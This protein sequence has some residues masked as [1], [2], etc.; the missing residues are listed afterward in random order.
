MVLGPLDEK[1]ATRGE[2]HFP[3]TVFGKLRLAVGNLADKLDISFNS[4][5]LINFQKPMFST[6]AYFLTLLF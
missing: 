6:N 5:S 1:E 2:V 4:K 3:I